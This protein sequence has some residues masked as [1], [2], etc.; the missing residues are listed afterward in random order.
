MIKMIKNVKL[1]LRLNE[2]MPKHIL[3]LTVEALKKVG[4]D[5]EGSRIAVFG[6]YL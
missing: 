2:Q 1:F 3:N 5:V 6:H 4:K